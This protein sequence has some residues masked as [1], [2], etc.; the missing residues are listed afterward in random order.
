MSLKYQQWQDI[1]LSTYVHFALLRSVYSKYNEQVVLDKHYYDSKMLGWPF[2]V[3][4][5][6]YVKRTL[7][8][9]IEGTL[10]VCIKVEI[11]QP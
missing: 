6:S 5:L 1:L 8:T 9:T 7:S 11:L 3:S 4:T 2:R 10:V